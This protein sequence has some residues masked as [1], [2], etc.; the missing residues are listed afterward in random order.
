M[1]ATVHTLRPRLTGSLD[2]DDL[3]EK[4]MLAGH[5]VTAAGDTIRIW[6]RPVPAA[7]DELR[8][9]IAALTAHYRALEAY[10]QELTP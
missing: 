10:E 6:T 5:A 3:A 4:V 2:I 8:R 7:M 1:A 9:T